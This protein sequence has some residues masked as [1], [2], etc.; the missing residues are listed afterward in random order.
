MNF[1]NSDPVDSTPKIRSMDNVKILTV[2][3]IKN[4]MIK[5]PDFLFTDYYIFRDEMDK[6]FNDSVIEVVK[7]SS[8]TAFQP[9]KING[10]P[11]SDSLA[12]R[13][14][15]RN[16]EL[17]FRTAEVS[18]DVDNR[19]LNPVYQRFSGGASYP[20]PGM[21]GF[22]KYSIIDLLEDHLITGG[23]RGK[24]NLFA[25]YLVFVNI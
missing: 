21:N 25:Y 14:K 4:R 8:N 13:A 22:M 24:G 20:M 12:P 15:Q 19:F 7:Q 1:L 18:L 16:Y 11:T 9:L 6:Q 5:D 23:F 10:F 17:S 3:S 2:D